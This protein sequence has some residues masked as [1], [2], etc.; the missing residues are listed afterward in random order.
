MPNTLLARESEGNLC[1]AIRRLSRDD[2]ALSRPVERTGAIVGCELVWVPVHYDELW[3][4][5]CG[6]LP[7]SNQASSL[8]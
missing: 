8:E 2:P 7:R 1:G 5:M 3:N 4:R 6:S